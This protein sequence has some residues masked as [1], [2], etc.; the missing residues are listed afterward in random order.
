[1]AVSAANVILILEPDYQYGRGSLRLRVESVDRANP[2]RYDN[3]AW[4]W[5]EGVQLTAG[6]AEIGHRKVLVRG[7]RLPPAERP[8][9]G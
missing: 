6:G 9:R 3:E 7:R 4:L 2:V 1:M 8:T 5:V